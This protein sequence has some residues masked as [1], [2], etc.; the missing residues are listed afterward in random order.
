MYSLNSRRLRQYGEIISPE[1][2]SSRIAYE[3]QQKLVVTCYDKPEF[4][5]LKKIYCNDTM[6][7]YG[8]GSIAKELKKYGLKLHLNLIYDEPGAIHTTNDMM[9][10][11]RLIVHSSCKETDAQFRGM[12]YEN[13]K[14][15]DGNELARCGLILVSQLRAQMAREEVKIAPPYSKRK[16]NVRETLK[17]SGNIQ[18]PNRKSE[19]DYMV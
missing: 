17:S 12:R 8:K 18:Q 19:Y 9:A 3:M 1:P 6:M 13:K 11:N 14:V 10:E 2:I 5:S 16:L 15:P 4:A 7:D